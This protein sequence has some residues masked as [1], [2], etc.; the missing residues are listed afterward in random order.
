VPVRAAADGVVA[1]V[2]ENAPRNMGI[3]VI[4]EHSGGYKTVYSNL[5]GELTADIGR[6]VEAGDVI[7]AVGN[8]AI[9]E[10]AMQPHLHFEIHK[11]G[12]PVDPGDY[13]H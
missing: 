8:S 6:V 3:T 9:A 10:S 11:N 13:L 4:I 12:E 2:L 1:D 7:G 5:S